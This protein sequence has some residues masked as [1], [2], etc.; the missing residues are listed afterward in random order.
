MILSGPSVCG[1]KKDVLSH[2]F[3]SGL[4]LPLNWL[5]HQQGLVM[6]ERGSTYGNSGYGNSGGN[7]GHHHHHDP[8]SYAGRSA[9]AAGRRTPTITAKKHMLKLVI[10]GDSG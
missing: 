6:Y 10:L 2:S 5:S 8:N 3:G 7:N 1:G 9:A 4:I